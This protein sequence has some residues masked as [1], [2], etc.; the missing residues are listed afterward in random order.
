M[1]EWTNPDLTVTF[2]DISKVPESAVGFIYFIWTPQGSYIGKKS[3]T[4]MA[5]NNEL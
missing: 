1:S 3:L 5:S 4:A 2:D